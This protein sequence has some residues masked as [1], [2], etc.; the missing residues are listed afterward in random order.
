MA[1]LIALAVVL[2]LWMA[3]RL[4]GA[5][6]LSPDLQFQVPSVPSRSMPNPQPAPL[7]TSPRTG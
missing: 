7:P 2:T 6:S 3:W 5:T 4:G 1:G